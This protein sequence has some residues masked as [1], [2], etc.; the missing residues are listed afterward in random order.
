MNVLDKAEDLA[1]YTKLASFEKQYRHGLI[2]RE[3][4]EKSYVSSR[5]HMEHGNCYTLIRSFDERF[6]NIFKGDG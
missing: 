4:I 2:T 6:E 3:K 1:A 5:G